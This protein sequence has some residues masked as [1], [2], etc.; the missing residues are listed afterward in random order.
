MKKRLLII[1]ATVLLLTLGTAAT[2]FAA[3]GDSSG[4][5]ASYKYRI[6]I[7]SGQ[8]GTFSTGKVWQKDYNVP[9]NGHVSISL[10]D[11][12]FKLTNDKYYPRGFRKT[13][14]DND[15]TTGVQRL[16]F[17]VLTEDVAYEV[18]YGIKG[19]MVAYTV[20]YEDENGT[21]LHDSDT[22]YGMAGDRPVVSYRYIEGYTPETYN[23]AK[24]LSR[25]ESENVFTFTYVEGEAPVTVVRRADGT[26]V[27]ANA[28]AAPGTAANPAG[29]AN[30]NAN[31]GAGANAGDGDGGTTIGDNG[32]PLADGPQQ[33]TDMDDNDVPQAEGL[34]AKN[35]IPFLIGSAVLLAIIIALILFFLKRRRA[36][37][38]GGGE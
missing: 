15:E 22:Y 9:L 17:D 26:P 36:E 11:L 1:L 32:T 37:E 33:F 4:D 29:T 38:T 21:T 7:Y 23:Q 10:D 16:E 28:A 30:A 2:A 24:T 27:P 34:F 8:Q 35:K 6:T 12:G 19:G 14:H 5:S 20:N 25:D 31:A 3:D 13:G 18:A